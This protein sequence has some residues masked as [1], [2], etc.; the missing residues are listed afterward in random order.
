M[1]KYFLSVKCTN[2]NCSNVNKPMTFWYD[3]PTTSHPCGVCGHMIT[4]CEAI[5]EEEFP[6][7]A[8]LPY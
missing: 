3:N 5:K 2:E 7:P 6:D 4:Y 1:I 8:P